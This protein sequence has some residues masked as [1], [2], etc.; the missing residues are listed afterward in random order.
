PE[1]KRILSEVAFWDVYYEHCSYFTQSSLQA[2][3]ENCGFEVLENSLEYK[4]Q[5]ITIYAKPD[6]RTESP[7]QPKA[8]ASSL[9][10]V[11]ADD[12]SDYQSKLQSTLELWSK[13][14][15][16]W[17]QAGK[18][19]CIWGSGSKSI[20]FIFTIPESR[21]IDFVVDINPHK[22]GNLM[23]GTH[24]QI[25]LPEKLKDISPDVV[26]IMNEIYLQEI[27]ADIAKMGLTPEI[28]ALS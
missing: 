27:S 10:S 25:V 18:K 19:V 14:L 1:T 5:Y 12:V 3:F 20:G 24:Q 22:N 16:A 9:T 17:S 6:P 8:L 26:I 21:C 7:A 4:D 11:S 28:L 13:R 23:P 2:V 15:D